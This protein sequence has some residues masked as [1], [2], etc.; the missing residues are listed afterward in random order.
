MDPGRGATG[1]PRGE[2]AGVGFESRTPTP[3]VRVPPHVFLWRDQ[4]LHAASNGLLRRCSASGGRRS[5][6]GRLT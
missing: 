5:L 1:R 2:S 6:R 3:L 4:R